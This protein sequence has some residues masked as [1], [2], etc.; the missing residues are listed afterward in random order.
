MKGREGGKFEGRRQAKTEKGEP[1]LNGIV[2]PL[3]GGGAGLLG[4][5]RLLRLV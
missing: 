1:V 3:L 4:L 5:L 2:T